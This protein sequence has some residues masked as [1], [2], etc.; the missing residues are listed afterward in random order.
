MS[1]A[2]RGCPE[3][4]TSTFDACNCSASS[5]DFIISAMC[6][7][8]NTSTTTTTKENQCRTEV[9]VEK[10]NEPKQTNET[11]ERQKPN[12]TSRHKNAGSNN[13]NRRQATGLAWW[14]L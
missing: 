4:F 5:S 9:D 12:E 3:F 13:G 8:M 7:I 10:E 2:A 6:R 11:A 14:H 1:E